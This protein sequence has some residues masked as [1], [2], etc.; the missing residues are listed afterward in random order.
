MKKYKWISLVVGIVSLVP[1]LINTTFMWDG[2]FGEMAFYT[3]DSFYIKPFLATQFVKYYVSLA[4]NGISLFT[5]VNPKVFV[6]LITVISVCGIAF[7]TFKLLK[8][9]F[10]FDEPY[11]YFGAWIVLAFPV[12][13]S[14]AAGITFL[15]I[16]CVWFF[17]I[18]VNLWRDKPFLAFVFLA[19]SLQFFS[20]FAFAVGFAGAE[21]MMTVNKG[22]VW[23]KLLKTASFCLFLVCIFI[24]IYMFGNIHQGGSYNTFN[25]ER[26]ADFLGFGLFAVVVLG[27]V[28]VGRKSLPGEDKKEYFT[29]CVLA[30]LVLAFFS[31]LAYWAVGRPLRFF[32]F[33]SFTSRFTYLTSIPCALGV[34][35]VGQYFSSRWSGKTRLVVGGLLLIA[36][37]VLQHQGHSHKAAAVV[38]KE[39]LTESFSQV[40]APPSGYVAVKAVGYEGP[41]HVHNYAINVCL[42]KAYGKSAWMA[43]GF[44]RR[45]MKLDKGTLE[46]LYNVD[47]KERKMLFAKDVT[48][49]NYTRYEFKLTDFHQEGR[50]WYWW[51][52]LTSD[53]SVFQPILTRVE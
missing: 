25:I 28:F 10:R 3:Q 7:E 26:L 37:L 48:G 32:A 5:G 35:I 39:A 8:K 19:I 52:F 36:F 44:W 6:N 11:A 30:F 18:A 38:F 23:R 43:N 31:G 53:Y 51:Y 16:L 13:H 45:K 29:R 21:F 1:L 49:D 42:Y 22:N 50:F 33:G 47:K 17:M 24:P 34:V 40:E 15:S 4:L 46:D 20:I 9:R 27:M 41:R 14:L 12:W 2:I